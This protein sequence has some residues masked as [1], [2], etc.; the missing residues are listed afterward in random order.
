MLGFLAAATSRIRLVTSVMVVPQRPA[1]LAAKALATVDVLSQGRLTVGVG[2]GW[3]TGQ[4]G[5]AGSREL[6]RSRSASSGVTHRSNAAPARAG[7]RD[8]VA[9]GLRLAHVGGQLAAPAVR[10]DESF[11]ESVGNINGVWCGGG[12]R[13]AQLVL[14]GP[15]TNAAVRLHWG[16][17]AK[18]VEQGQREGA[19]IREYVEKAL[20]SARY[21][22]LEDGTFYGEVPRLR[23]ALATG[24]TLEECRTQ[25]AEV[26]EEWVLVRVAK[27]LTVPP[28][29]K[30]E[31]RVKKAS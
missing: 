13:W 2:V 25:L 14:R 17:R 8:R 18:N 26:V 30:I 15:F 9:L 29:G 21:D 27:G 5:N 22:K 10:D 4:L 1:V 6:R 20:R 19:M 16:H 28:L 24:G 23:D 12:H 3:M 11:K 31:V 7:D